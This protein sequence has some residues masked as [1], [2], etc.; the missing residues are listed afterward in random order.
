MSIRIITDSTADMPDVDVAKV[1]VVPMTIMFDDGEYID[2]VT[3]SKNEFYQKL[4]T[5]AHLPKTS[6]VIPAQFE[7]V[8]DEVTAAGDEAIVLTLP[9]S[10][11]GTYQ[12]ACIAAA[13][14]DNIRVIDGGNTAMGLGVMVKYAIRCVEEGMSLE[15]A[16]KA[17]REKREKCVLVALLGTLEYLQKGGRVSKSVA[18]A[19]TLLNIKPVIALKRGELSML[20]KARGSKKG[21]NYLIE[22]VKAH[23][24]DYDMPILLGY[25]GCSDELLSQY[26]EDN[27]ELWEGKIP[28]PERAQAG[29]TIG[30]HIGPGA[31][32]VAFFEQD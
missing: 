32:A 22:Q 18:F 6:Q 26:M 20:G 7:A 13:D 14:R 10:L 21:N 3:I 5:A 2:G 11:S 8:F 9:A 30:T 28:A 12:S 19:G 29:S 27:H 24:I 15:E 16:E 4:E 31:I 1:T 17:I 25:T 23:G